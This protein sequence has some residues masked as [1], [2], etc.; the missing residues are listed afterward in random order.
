MSFSNVADILMD[1]YRASR[2]LPNRFT[3]APEPVEEERD[4]LVIAGAEGDPTQE[5]PGVGEYLLQ[6]GDVWGKMLESGVVGMA[7]TPA[8]IESIGRGVSRAI[9]S[10][11]DQS[12][13]DAF[14]EGFAAPTMAPEAPE[15]RSAMESVGL[16]FEPVSEAYTASPEALQPAERLGEI[17]GVPGAGLAAAQTSKQ[18]IRQL[19]PAK[20]QGLKLTPESLAENA[21]KLW[22]DQ[23]SKS[24][25][26]KYV[27]ALAGRRNVEKGEL[28]H[29]K[30]CGFVMKSGYEPGD[31]FLMFK[32]SGQPDFVAHT[33]VVDKSGKIKFDNFNGEWDSKTKTYMAPEV[34]DKGK[35]I[36]SEFR[37]FTSYEQVDVDLIQKAADLY[38]GIK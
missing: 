14:K 18:I 13:W 11:E 33:I 24:T 28:C 19:R 38:K 22:A 7:E 10:P 3:P 35:A 21:T 23:S 17:I 15:I 31:K 12:A 6:I 36:P 29:D 5:R 34:D 4:P 20:I 2:G 25:L 27:E 37:E 16:G 30:A 8:F 9:Q 1:D 32:T 26:K